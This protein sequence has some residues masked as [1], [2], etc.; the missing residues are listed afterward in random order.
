MPASACA[1]QTVRRL[2]V[3]A[4]D[5]A[6]IGACHVL[7]A[8]GLQQDVTRRTAETRQGHQVSNA[9]P[10]LR[11]KPKPGLARTLCTSTAGPSL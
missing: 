2:W 9:R 7:L 8:A 11:T 6:L 4:L 1:V 3:L 5:F 10:T